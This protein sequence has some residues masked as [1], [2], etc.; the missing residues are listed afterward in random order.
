MTAPVTG[1]FPASR[2]GLK[3]VAAVLVALLL[4][5]TAYAASG[6]YLAVRAIRS[7]V[8]DNDAAALAGYVDFPALR[9]SLKAQLQDRL[10]RRAGEDMQASAI[11]ALGLSIAGGVIDG[12]ID[13]MVTPLGIGALMQGRIIASRLEGSFATVVTDNARAPVQDAVYRYESASRV[14]A[15]VRT[16]S[17]TP[18]VMVLTR[19]GLHWRLSDVRLAP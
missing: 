9:G 18:V 2:R 13:S 4:G 6:P 15:T 5:I 1:V 17:G 12:A 10:A 14:T 11:G 3:I 19:N 16:Q 8:R 7:A